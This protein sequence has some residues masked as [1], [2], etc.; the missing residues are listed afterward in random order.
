MDTQIKTPESH[1]DHPVVG[2]RLRGPDLKQNGKNIT[3]YCD[4]YDPRLGFWLQST[5]QDDRRINISERAV[6]GTFHLIH[7]DDW[8]EYTGHGYH[9]RY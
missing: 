1:P 4:S 2:H 6:G 7:T 8:G 9:I 3:W 5:E